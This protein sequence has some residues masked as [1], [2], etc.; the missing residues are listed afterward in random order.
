MVDYIFKV[1]V[2]CITY[3]HAPYILDAMNGFGKQ[4]TN[5]PFVCTIIDDSSTDGEQEVIKKYL[6][7]NFDLEDNNVVRNEETEDYYLIFTQHKR[8][9]NCFFAVLLLKYNH[10]Q[11]NKNKSQYI[12]EWSVNSNYTAFCE[13]DDYWTDPLKLQKQVDIL[14]S[15]PEVGLVYSQAEIIDMDKRKTGGIWGSDKCQLDDI[16]VKNNIPTLTVVY[17][18]SLDDQ[19]TS[20]MGEVLSQK[21]WPMGDKPLWLWM[22]KHSKLFYIPELLGVYRIVQNSASHQTNIEKKLYFTKC[23]YELCQYFDQRFNDG[24]MKIGIEDRYNRDVFKIYARSHPSFF[25]ALRYYL[26][27]HNKTWQDHK[28]LIKVLI[29]RA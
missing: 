26:K 11:L 17:R 4:E 16:L 20:E 2:D 15:H 9:R 21:K 5:F 8:N 23:N 14:D 24:K 3:N 12:S 25:K 10:H 1:R 13:G 18:N 27:I 6:Q 7:E 28:T 29:K 22:A 19:Y